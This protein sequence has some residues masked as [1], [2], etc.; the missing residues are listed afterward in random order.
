MTTSQLDRLTHRCHILETG[1]V[2]YLFKASSERAK[3]KRNETT[4]L[5]PSLRTEHNNWLG[6][7]SVTMLDQISVTINYH[8]RA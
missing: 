8:G 1:N 3:K 2:S 5:T 7:V 4:T 6:Q